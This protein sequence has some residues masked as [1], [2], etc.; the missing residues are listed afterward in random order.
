MNDPVLLARVETGDG[1]RIR[2]L[3]PRVGLWSSHP[4]AGALLGPGSEAGLFEVLNRRWSLRL[5]EGARGRLVGSLPPDHVV[6]VE[7]G[8]T[9]FELAPIEVA[10]AAS[11]A[12]TGSSD[13]VAAGSIDG[14]HVVAAPTDGVFYRSPSPGA[15]PFVAE[16]SRIRLGQ[17]FGLIEVMKTF[18]QILYDGPGL[19]QEGE[20]VEFR[21]GDG[22]EV[23]AGAPLL[24][25]R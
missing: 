3:A 10:T 19:P 18:N 5:P 15:P 7:F 4:H 9:L 24:V 12:G 21:C 16:G 14:A 2:V 13:G 6:P 17:P 20:V 22:E 23:R 8:Q 25:V 1:G 11:A